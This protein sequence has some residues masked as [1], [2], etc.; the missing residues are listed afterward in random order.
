MTPSDVASAPNVYVTLRAAGNEA[1]ALLQA[2]G[3]GAR[4]EVR[5]LEP[6]EDYEA[7]QEAPA[8]PVAIE[9]SGFVVVPRSSER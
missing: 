9:G 8:R 4:V 6:V 7:Q 1:L 5:V 3:E 2:L